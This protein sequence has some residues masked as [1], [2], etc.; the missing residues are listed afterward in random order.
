MEASL[1]ESRPAPVKRVQLPPREEE[2]QDLN[3]AI[4]ASLR[5]SARDF[6]AIE[7]VVDRVVERPRE[8]VAQASIVDVIS[9]G[10]LDNIDLFSSIIER[11]E[12]ESAGGGADDSI[13]YNTEIQGM[14]AKMGALAP[15]LQ[16]SMRETEEKLGGLRELD[17]RVMGGCRG[18]DRMVLARIQGSQPQPYASQRYHQPVEN[19]YAQQ[20]APFNP[21]QLPHQPVFNQQAQQ[22]QPAYNPQ[23]QPQIN[24]QLPPQQQGFNPA[25]TNG[26]VSLI[27]DTPLIDL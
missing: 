5:E 11:M 26:G 25:Y 17:D 7:R 6:Q 22:P 16:K 2:D 10:D 23:Q 14:Y 20:Q 13:L 12:Q 8:V 9:R 18:Y 4:Q 1:A 15:K 24:Q 3:A 19:Q 27:D 21:Q